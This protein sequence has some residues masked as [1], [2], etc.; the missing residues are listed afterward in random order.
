MKISWPKALKKNPPGVVKL[1]SIEQQGSE[2]PG[3]ESNRPGLGYGF[4]SSKP[5]D[6]QDMLNPFNLQYPH[7]RSGGNSV[8]L[9]EL[10]GLNQMC[11]WFNL[12]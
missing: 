6:L 9:I 2:R 1:L 3:L 4:C 8:N 5:R 10:R 12:G 7:L 11:A